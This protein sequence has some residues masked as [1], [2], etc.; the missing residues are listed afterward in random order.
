MAS[1]IT[2]AFKNK[3]RRGLC[4][5]GEYIK[6]LASGPEMATRLIGVGYDAQS[7]LISSVSQ[8]YGARTE[9]AKLTSSVQ[10]Q[11]ANFAQETATKNQMADLEVI[12]DKLKALLTEAQAMATMATS[13]F[14][15]LH[16]G[17]NVSASDSVSTSL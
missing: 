13:L 10:V 8:F 12:G 9:A 6:A 14:N 5:A 16:T 2:K 3:A 4:A 1:N 7:K 11:N 17:A 15:N